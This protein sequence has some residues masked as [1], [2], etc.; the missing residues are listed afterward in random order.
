MHRLPHLGLL[1]F[2]AALLVCLAAPAVARE[3][4]G[5]MRGKVMEVHPDVMEFVLADEAGKRLRFEME[6]DATVLINGREATLAELQPG[7]MVSVV[8]MRQGERWMA[9]EVRCER[10]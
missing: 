8:H 7:D 9:I 4:H 2:L 5:E 10:K 3:S 1:A 6:E